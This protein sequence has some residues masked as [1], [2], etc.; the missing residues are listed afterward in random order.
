MLN[1]LLRGKWFYGILAAVML[2]ILGGVW[3]LNACNPISYSMY[4]SD[5]ISFQKGR[6][7]SVDT[8]KLSP[9]PGETNRFLG[10]QELTV[11]MTEGP[12]KGQDK[13]ITNNLSNTHNI[14]VSPG[15]RVVVKVDHPENAEPYLTIYNYD[16]TMGILAIVLV[17]VAAMALV[18]RAKGVK[19]VVGLLFTLVFIFTFLLPMIY[20]G[21]SPILVCVATILVTASFSML[22]LNGLSR[23]TA[24]AIGS[25]MLGVL[26]AAAFYGIFSMILHVNGYNLEEAEEL[27]LIH[28]NTGLQIPQILFVGILIA[29]LGA[30]MDMTMS[31]ASSLYEIKQIHPARTPREIVRSGMEIGRD[32]IGTMCETLILAFAGTGLTTMLVLVAYGAQFDQLLSSDYLGIELLHSVTGSMAVVASVPITALLSAW[33]FKG[34]AAKAQASKASSVPTAV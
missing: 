31:V 2:S 27:I 11:R 21:Y 28:Q 29:S 30:V 23:K 7:Q 18:G 10:T 17:F 12:W 4:T 15:Q 24:V 1:K 16:R 13:K 33:F 34:K 20:H 14:R 19:S 5:A 22:L 26:I 32:M 3:L 6:V 9:A 25:T 8:E